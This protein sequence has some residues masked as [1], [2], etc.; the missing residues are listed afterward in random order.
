MT[1]MHIRGTIERVEPS[2]FVVETAHGDVTVSLP[3]K[4]GVAQV[5]PGTRADIKPG[6]FIGA[7]NVPN[8]ATDRALEVVVF[9]NAMRGT[10]E[11][12]YGWDLAP[13]SGGHSM[14]T[15]G[16]V[17]PM[18]GHS[19]MTNGNVAHESMNGPMT[20]DVTYKGGQQHIVVPPNAPIVR[21][22]PGTRAMIAKG[23]HVFV[24]ATGTMAH[25]TA[26]RVV[27]GEQGAVPPM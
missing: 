21:I 11:G 27:V 7:A 6:T 23:A 22:E 20:L 14:M 1:P 5:V 19:M 10:G 2:A 4:T 16:T 15:N 3:A 17:A 26:L 13:P 8:G 18:S 9:P 25:A 24:V 12:N